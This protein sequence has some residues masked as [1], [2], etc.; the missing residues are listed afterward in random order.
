MKTASRFFLFFTVVMIVSCSAVFCQQEASP[1]LPLDHWA[2]DYIERLHSRHYL[3]TL[4][5]SVRPYTRMQVAKAILIADT[6]ITLSSVEKA[7]L[8]LLKQEFQHE[9]YAIQNHSEQ[10]QIH[11]QADLSNRTY[12][13]RSRISAD[14]RFDPETGLSTEHFTGVLRGRVDRSLLRDNTYSGRRTSFAGARIED[15]YGR[16]DYGVLFFAIGRYA[17]EW[18]PVYGKS[19]ILSSNPYSYDKISFGLNTPHILFRSMFAMLDPVSDSR[20]FFSAHRLDLRFR[21][22]MQ[23][24]FSETVIYGGPHQIPDLSYINPFSIF[25]EVQLN[26][27]KEA[28]ENLAFDFFVPYRQFQFSGQILI[29]DFILDGPGKPPPNRKTSPDRL[30]FLMN[31]LMNDPLLKNSQLI[32]RYERVGSYTYN[33]KQKRPWQSYTYQNRGLGATSNDCDDLSLMLN[34]Y[35]LPHWNFRLETYVHRQ[36][37]RTILSHDFEDSTFVKLPFPS[38]RVEKRTGVIL[39]AG[40]QTSPR[41]YLRWSSGLEWIRNDN[42]QKKSKISV[43]VD[44]SLAYQLQFY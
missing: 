6:T 41:I 29:D 32:L 5:R 19:L 42:H 8:E 15:G 26:Q 27:K 2:Y 28:N 1:Y 13:R 34:Y 10:V 35:P 4:N 33:V 11:A 16:L 3:N 25:A 43:S 31:V 30:G 9:T 12:Y 40:Y 44:F 39:L 20:R 37:E 38:G 7:W 17:E 22:G 18:S 14:Y 23:L 24:G 36:G 21:N